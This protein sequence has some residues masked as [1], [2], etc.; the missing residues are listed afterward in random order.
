MARQ[1]D[2]QQEMQLGRRGEDWALAGPKRIVKV[3][4]L[5]P[6]G[7]EPRAMSGYITLE[8]SLSLKTPLQIGQTLGLRPGEL[9]GGCRVFSFQRLPSAGEYEY[10]LT[11]FYPGGLAFNPADMQ[12]ARSE[13]RLKNNG[14]KV[15]AW[16][17]GSRFVHQWLLKFEIPVTRICDVMPGQVYRL[18]W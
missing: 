6:R 16:P 15:N 7:D 18:K 1:T 4:S 5:V 3:K 12:E 11:A 14:G 10:E 9:D 17:P 8:R 13:L 2:W